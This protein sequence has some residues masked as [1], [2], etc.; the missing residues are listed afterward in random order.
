MAFDIVCVRQLVHDWAAKKNRVVV[1][2]ESV[3]RRVVKG[4]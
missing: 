3:K 2:E 1:F 4:S